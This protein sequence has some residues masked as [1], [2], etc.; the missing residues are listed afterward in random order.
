MARSLP[1]RTAPTIIYFIFVTPK[2]PYGSKII[3]LA[4]F[5]PL[6]IAS[7]FFFYFLFRTRLSDAGSTPKP[8]VTLFSALSYYPNSQLQE[9]VSGAEVP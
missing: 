8:R 9:K 3:V 4:V 5:D 6:T 1:L 7:H 2:L